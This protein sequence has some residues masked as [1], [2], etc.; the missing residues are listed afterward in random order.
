[1]TLIRTTRFTADAAEADTVLERRAKLL[2]AVRAAFAGPTETQLVRIDERTWVDTW[3][4]DSPET[5]NAA[6]EGA[7]RLPE[8]AAAF[9]VARDVTAEQ[10]DLVV[11]DIWAR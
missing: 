3:R 8:A 5:L 10:G 6:L 9:A 11:E 4:W 7:P 2:E 1:M